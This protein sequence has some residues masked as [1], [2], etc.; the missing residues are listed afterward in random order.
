M[1]KRLVLVLLTAGIAAVV[2]I[3]AAAKPRGT[4]GKIVI[5]ADNSVTGQEQVY[6][7]DPDG[8]DLQLLAN[9]AEAGQWSPDGTQIAMNGGILNFDTGSFT[10]L[11][12]GTLYPDLFLG[13]TTWSPDGT[14]L[15]CE[16]GFTDPSL[17]GIYTLRSS[18]GGDLQRVTSIPG[19][20]D[21][22]GDYS[23]N[24]NRIVFI[25]A[26]ENFFGLATVKLDG[27]DLRQITPPMFLNFNCG[28]W[29]PQRNEIL[30]SAHVPDNNY[31]STTWVIHSDGSGLRQIPIPDCGGLISDPNSISCPNPSW[32]P[33]GQK[34]VFSRFSAATGQ[35]DIYTVNLDGSALTQVTNT[36]GVDEFTADWGTHPVTP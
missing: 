1:R 32:S 7:V 8:S 25:R 6:T 12:L 5:N 36:P 11:S 24:G 33:D 35:R 2:A 22:P 27:S 3:P 31:R 34:I 4:N 17:Q 26:S 19:G 16:G 13:C 15:G 30:F 28:S 29:S 21:C 14:R 10:D 20:D 23:P 18:D 9:D